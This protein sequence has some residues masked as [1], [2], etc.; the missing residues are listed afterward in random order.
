MPRWWNGRHS[1]LRGCR[2]RACGFKSR[3]RHLGLCRNRQGLL[4]LRRGVRLLEGPHRLGVAQLGRA[5]A[6][7]AGG[8]WFE[9]THPDQRVV[10]QL[11][12]APRSGRG[13]QG[14]ESLLL[15]VGTGQP[16]PVSSSCRANRSA[17]AGAASSIHRDVA[18]R[19]SARLGAVKSGFRDAPS[20]PTKCEPP[21]GRLPVPRLFSL[22]Q[23]RLAYQPHG[24]RR[25]FG[26]S[27][28]GLGR[29]LD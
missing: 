21:A 26:Q 11:G 29:F 4:S 5:P 15:D 7:E 24:R 8:R 9:S 3:S 17:C 13:G 19:Q 6:L 2:F 20:R 16:C 1:S 18:Q 10:A 28:G 12:R 22:T 23:H 27:A 14:F 25:A